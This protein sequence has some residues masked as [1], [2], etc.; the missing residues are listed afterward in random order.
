MDKSVVRGL[1][2][3]RAIKPKDYAVTLVKAMRKEKIITIYPTLIKAGL[4]ISHYMPPDPVSFKKDFPS[5]DSFY[6]TA[7]MYFES[8]KRYMT[9]LN[10]VFEGKS[11]LPEKGQDEDSMETFMF[12]HVDDNSTLVG[13][14]LRVKDIILDKPGVY[15]IIFKIFEDIDGKPGDLL[16]EKSCSIVAARAARY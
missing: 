15:D 1:Q 5:K 3:R 10:V 12:V 9:E 16:D 13:S 14:S 6:L 7:L 8:G 4:A 2:P 11:V